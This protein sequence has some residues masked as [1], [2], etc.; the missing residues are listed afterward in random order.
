MY[1][2]EGWKDGVLASWG[3]MALQLQEAHQVIENLSQQLSEL[4]DHV[5]ELEQLVAEVSE[6]ADES[7]GSPAKA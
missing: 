1:F 4:R 5:D 3:T 2:T 7:S 6:A